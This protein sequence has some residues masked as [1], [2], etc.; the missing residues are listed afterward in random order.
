MIE[1]WMRPLVFQAAQVAFR[2][3][4]SSHAFIERGFRFLN[5]ALVGE[6]LHIEVEVNVSH[7]LL[8]HVHEYL[9]SN[10]HQYCYCTR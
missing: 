4:S 3:S 9:T 2:L 8:I 6:C 10:A 5:T 1:R 7:L